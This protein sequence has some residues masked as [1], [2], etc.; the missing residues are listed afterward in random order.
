[1]CTDKLIKI[2]GLNIAI[3][4]VD[5]ILF[6]P[7]LLGL[8]IGGLNI[9]ATAFGATAMLMSV[10]VFV[11]GN[12]RLLIEKEKTIQASEIKTVEDCIIVLR[13]NYDKR[14][15]R[16]DIES[17]LEQIGRFQKKKETI[18]DILLQKFSSTEMSYS[19]FV[20]AISDIENVF[21]INIK[22]IINKINAFDEDDY[23]WILKDNSQKKFSSEIMHTKMSIYNEYISFVKNASEDS[24]KIILKFDKLL[25]EISKFNSLEDG[26]IETMSAMKE[27]DELIDKTK[28][29]K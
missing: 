13:H 20:G 14:P 24:E 17:I 18:K 28:F 9:L 2:A 12:Y 26:E 7:S 19:K 11:Y 5:T 4:G 29:Y 25:L 27:I 6:S 15:F 16:K 1:M 21:Y 3:V 23:N 8:Q 22:S 10:V